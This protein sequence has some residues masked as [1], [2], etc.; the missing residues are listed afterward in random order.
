MTMLL[1]SSLLNDHGIWTTSKLKPNDTGVGRSLL[2][3]APPVCL[4]T[5]AWVSKGGCALCVEFNTN[6]L[7]CLLGSLQS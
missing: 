4:T 2:L 3:R 7:S 1:E 6:S 5:F